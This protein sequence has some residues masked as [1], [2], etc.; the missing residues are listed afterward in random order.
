V[1][2]PSEEIV[3]DSDIEAELAGVLGFPAFS[4]TTM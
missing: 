1:L 4:S 3:D 2:L